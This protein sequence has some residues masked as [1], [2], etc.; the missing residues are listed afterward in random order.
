MTEQASPQNPF[1]QEGN[2]S[3]AN[4]PIPN[5][6]LF[7]PPEQPVMAK[8]WYI[9]KGDSRSGPFT[10]AAVINSIQ[11]REYTRNDMGWK[12]GMPQWQL[13]CSIDEF[14]GLFKTSEHPTIPEDTISKILKETVN[15]VRAFTTFAINPI[16][17]LPIAYNKLSKNGAMLVGF[18]FTLFYE[19]LYFLSFHKSFHKV[20]ALIPDLGSLEAKWGITWFKI[21]LV[22]LLPFIGLS[23]SLLVI[24][25]KKAAY[26]GSIFIAGS[27]LLT[28]G[29]VIF[30]AF[31]LGVANIEIIII[32]GLVLI[33][34]IIFI[35]YSGLTR[36]I[37]VSEAKGV[38]CVPAVLL[39]SA[40]ITK[41]IVG[42]FMG[43]LGR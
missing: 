4:Q 21:A 10:V 27:V 26:H 7:T 22:L 3:P 35:L 43:Q 34:W 23:I 16:E 28:E 41:I 11:N 39:A 12:K 8:E 19:I 6:S 1:P 13:L 32:L 15:A 38:W 14:A 17:G 18:I 31:M 9:G 29:I 36:I 2:V 24:S 5:A 33:C 37:G 20:I 42:M 25:G 40:Y 30:L